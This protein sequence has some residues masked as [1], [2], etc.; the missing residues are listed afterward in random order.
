MGA[1]ST[2]LLVI[3][4]QRAVL[5]GCSDAAELVG[6]IN[7][8]TRRAG[9]AGAAVIFIQ[10]EDDDELV[11][12]SP[13]WELAEGL[14]RAGGTSL[15]PKAYRDGFAATELEALLARAGVRRLILTGAHS[16][17]CVQTTAL[18]ALVRGF[19]I[20]LVSDAHAASSTATAGL[21]PEA[22]RAFVNDRF[23]TLRYPQRTI[24]VLPAADVV[25]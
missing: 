12:G 3:D 18:S 7:D 19:D 17:F 8:L 23:A 22:L 14:E 1:F 4:M 6:R 24:E 20:V 25:L 13:G 5:A 15:V 2:A 21:S 11:K 16:D 10:H 9:E